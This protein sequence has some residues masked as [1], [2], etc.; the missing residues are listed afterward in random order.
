MNTVRASFTTAELLKETSMKRVAIALVGVFALA[1]GSAG[2]AD[3]PRR[4]AMP[5][6]AP[7]YAPIYNWT[8]LYL[9][10][11]GG[12]TWGHSAWSNPSTGDFNVSG[13][14]IGGTVGYN[15]QSGNIVLGAEAD[16]SWVNSKGDTNVTCPTACETSQ[17]WLGTARGRVGYAFDRFLPYLTAGAAFGDIKADRRGFAGRDT[18]NVGWTVGGGLEFAI[19]G[20]WTAKA[21]YLYVDLGDFDCGTAC[22]GVAPDTVSLRENVMRAGLNYRF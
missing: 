21:E 2:A 17:S 12:G 10:L 9:G 1:V 14:L 15:W 5:T 4:T 7:A 22:G 3:L 8:G 20:N 18:T 16:L 11:T 13:G 19:A 6:K